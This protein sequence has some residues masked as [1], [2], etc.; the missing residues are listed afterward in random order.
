MV[1]HVFEENRQ[2]VETPIQVIS[3]F[4][5]SFIRDL[6]SIFNIIKT[7]FVFVLL[8]VVYVL[9]NRDMT[10][11]LIDPINRIIQKIKRIQQDPSHS[12]KLQPHKNTDQQ[13]NIFETKE[14]ELVMTKIGQ[15]LAVTF[16][17]AGNKIIT[18]N[19]KNSNK[20]NARIP[21]QKVYGVY[22]FIYIRHFT[23]TVDVLQEAVMLYV[24]EISYIVHDYVDFYGGA[25]NKNIG[26]AYLLIWKIDRKFIK[27]KNGSTEV[28]KCKEVSNIVDLALF[29]YIRII[30]DINTSQIIRKYNLHPQLTH[31]MDHF[32]VEL[33]FGMHVGWAIEGAIGSDFKIDASYL[34]PNVNI[35]AR[36]CSATK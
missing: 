27:E 4:D 19:M 17:D 30:I 3:V 14:L 22:G 35:A 28:K 33:S 24:N 13:G 31:K 25:T 26:E 7:I 34:S 18:E 9:Q 2:N 12:K 20:I 16:G 1:F 5:L 15:L 11:I 8:L 21:G 10:S 36:L 23:E 29:S 6:N 32:K